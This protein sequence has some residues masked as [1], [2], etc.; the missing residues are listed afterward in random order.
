MPGVKRGPDEILPLT[1]PVKVA[2]TSVRGPDGENASLFQDPP[3]GARWFELGVQSATLMADTLKAVFGFA[4]A[5]FSGQQGESPSVPVSEDSS[6]TDGEVASTQRYLAT[7]PPSVRPS[8]Q[9][10]LVQPQPQPVAGPSRQNVATLSQ[11]QSQRQHQS[12]QS[13]GRKRPEA[14]ASTS[15]VASSQQRRSREATRTVTGLPSPPPSRTTSSSSTSFLGPYPDIAEKLDEAKAIDEGA[16]LQKRK[17]LV[18][19]RKH[20]F[21]KQVSLPRVDFAPVEC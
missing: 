17:Q 10:Q 16:A 19:H 20:I 3:L 12:Q 11:N 21:D 13:L 8:P 7:P 1:R 14:Q 5:K 9:P 18:K 6:P 15:T 4:K 2:R